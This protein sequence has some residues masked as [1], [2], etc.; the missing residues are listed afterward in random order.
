MAQADKS[1]AERARRDERKEA[2]KAAFAMKRRRFIRC[3]SCGHM[4]DMHD[5][6]DILGHI[7]QHEAPIRH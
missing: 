1:A 7:G 5:V 4:V 3:P 2:V 6:A